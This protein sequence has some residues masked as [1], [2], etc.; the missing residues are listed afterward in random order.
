[1]LKESVTSHGGL[2]FYVEAP[3]SN[4]IDKP[5]WSITER[6]RPTSK[7]FQLAE[8]IQGMIDEVVHFDA[9]LCKKN[10]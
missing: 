2:V 10:S 5:H 1:M 4:K 8:D 3:A 9:S 7:A 6:T